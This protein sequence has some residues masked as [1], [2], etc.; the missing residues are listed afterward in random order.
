MADLIGRK[1]QRDMGAGEFFFE[2]DLRDDGVIARNYKFRRPWGLPVRYHDYRALAARSNPEFLE[3]HMS[4]RDIELSV[5][6][7]V[8]EPVPLGLVVHSPDLFPGDHILN[9][10][11]DDTDYRRRSAQELQRVV[12]VTRELAERFRTVGKPLIVAS[13][14]GFSSDGPIPPTDSLS[15]MSESPKACT[16]S[17][18]KGWKYS[19]R[20]SRRSPGTSAAS[21][22][23]TYS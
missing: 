9:L 13:L 10:A 11:A 21:C 4:Y 20:R 8:P 6:E 14:G 23:A 1:V 19:L 17:T 2:S 22:S 5:N 7:M 18:T 12:N 15:S 16:L 3:F